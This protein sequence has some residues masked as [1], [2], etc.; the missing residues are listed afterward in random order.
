MVGVFLIFCAVVVMIDARAQEG[1]SYVPAS[2]FKNAALQGAGAYGLAFVAPST[3]GYGDR[4]AYAGSKFAGP[5]AFGF[6]GAASAG[7]GPG[8]YAF[9]VF[10][11]NQGH[12]GFGALGYYGTNL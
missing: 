2:T 12:G 11:H 1:G 7:L 9:P 5:G 3:Y 10:D 6:E 8:R 4:G